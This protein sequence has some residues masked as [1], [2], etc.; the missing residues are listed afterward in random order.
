MSL[1]TIKAKARIYLKDSDAEWNDWGGY[2]CRVIEPG[3]EVQVC[4][5]SYPDGRV[6]YT[7]YLFEEGRLYTATNMR[8]E[9]GKIIEN[10]GDGCVS[11]ARVCRAIG[12]CYFRGPGRRP[13]NGG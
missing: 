12:V 1:R 2:P 7:A 3:E 6:Y 10:C 13:K 9:N 4:V 11:R 5:E 8:D